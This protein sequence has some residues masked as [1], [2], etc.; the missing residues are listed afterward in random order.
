MTTLKIASSQFAVSDNIDKNISHI[1]KQIK[2]ASNKGVNL[3]HF[4]ECSLSAYA[5]IDF[6]AYNTTA[7]KKI[8]NGITNICE[9][10]LLHNIWVIFGTHFFESETKKPF[11]CL[12]VVNNKGK[13][14][15]RYNKRLLAQFDLDWYSAGKEP[16]IFEIKG[17]KC[18]L[19]ICHEWRYP[20][21]YRQYYKLGVQLLFQSWYD[22]NYSEQ[23]YLE[24]GKNLGEVI[25]GFARGNAANNKLWISASNTSKKQQGFPAFVCRPDGVIQGKLKRNTSG[26]LITEIDFEKEYM[27][28]SSHLRDEVIKRNY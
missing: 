9:L 18:G 4:C 22:G 7:N 14:E 10:A 28:L 1:K 23:E 20:E 19:L 17:I 27:D 2:N 12:F 21:L 3:I 25:P 24:E 11:N 26:I 15:T 13:I 6:P 8:E 16:G 5:G